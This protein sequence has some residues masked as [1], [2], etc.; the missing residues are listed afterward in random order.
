[1]AEFGLGTTFF[2]TTEV[3]NHTREEHFE[4]GSI[5]AGPYLENPGINYNIQLGARYETNGTIYRAF[6]LLINE[7][8]SETEAR[9]NIWRIWFGLGIGKR[10]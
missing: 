3:S 9:E 6:S 8:P 7:Y 1:M 4:F 5:Y 2:F 10:F